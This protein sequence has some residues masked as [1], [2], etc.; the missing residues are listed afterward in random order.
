MSA[1]VSKRHWLA[2]LVFV[3][4]SACA[5]QPAIRPERR[6]VAPAAVERRAPSAEPPSPCAVASDIEPLALPSLEPAPEPSL[7]NLKAWVYALAGPELRGRA[8][9]TPDAARAARLIADYFAALGLRAP[10][11]SEYCQAFSVEQTSDQNVVAHWPSEAACHVIVGAHYDAL[12][13]DREGRVRPGADDDASGMAVLLE[14]AR[15]SASAAFRPRVGL[16]LAAFGAEE[17]GLLGSQ[18]YVLSPSL[19]LERARLMINVDMAGRRPRG[20]PAL[21]YEASGPEQRRVARDVAT[22]GGRAGVGLIPMRLGDRGD[23]ASFSPHVPT[24]FF[25]TTAHRDYHQPSDTPERVDYEQVMRALRVV[26]ELIE[27]VEC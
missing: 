13:V 5:S 14:L 26:L 4:V 9:T 17:I 2:S 3:C 24:V 15:L 1:I 18:A 25:S 19:P 22:A 21:G 16:V 6:L 11:G 8:A 23:S 12:G 7:P 20:N 10:F 27:K